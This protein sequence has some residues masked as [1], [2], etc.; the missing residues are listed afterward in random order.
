[1]K[2]LWF[3]Y[4]IIQY[5]NN[6]IS[7]KIKY[8]YNKKNNKFI[9]VNAI[10]FYPSMNEKLL[11]N[12]ITWAR[13]CESISLEDKEIILESKK[14]I[15]FNELRNMGKEANNFDIAQGSFDGG[16]PKCNVL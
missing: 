1:M 10:N 3:I 2:I 16:L 14:S 13:Q 12:V 6:L 8:D 15:I 11:K 7:N 9:R 5:V 4:L